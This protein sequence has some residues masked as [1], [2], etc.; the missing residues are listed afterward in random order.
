MDGIIFAILMSLIL[1][2]LHLSGLL[3][4]ASEVASAVPLGQ[5]T[6]IALLENLL[7]AVITIAFWVLLGATPGKC[8]LECR[9]VSARTGRPPGWLRATL[10]YLCYIVSLLP[11]GLGFFWI[12]WDRR[13]QGWH[14]KIA[15]TLVVVE[16]LAS[17]SFEELQ[18]LVA[19]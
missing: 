10:R 19:N 4:G 1:F 17:E 9:V 15:G 12:A 5:T 13:K 7:P 2:G 8:L 11:L 18:R 14:D 6:Q 3:G 16:D